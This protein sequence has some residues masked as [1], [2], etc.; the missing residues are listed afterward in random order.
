ML[1]AHATVSTKRRALGH[2]LKKS[3]WKTIT[4]PGVMGDK[5]KLVQVSSMV[6][7]PLATPLPRVQMVANQ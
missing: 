7:F 1:W 3:E 6:Y 2:T 5:K 4:V